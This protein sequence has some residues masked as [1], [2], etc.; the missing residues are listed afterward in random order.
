[1]RLLVSPST[2]FI[3]F[4]EGDTDLDVLLIHGEADGVVPV[5][6]SESFAT[7]L[8]EGGV[9]VELAILPGVNHSGVTSPQVVGD[10]IVDWIEG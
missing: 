2:R 10:L 4:P 3:G 5:D 6:F 1:M 8:A 9:P 7:A